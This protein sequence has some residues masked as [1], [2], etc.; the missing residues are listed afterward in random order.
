MRRFGV[1]K[2]GPSL[3]L[4]ERRRRELI[5]RIERERAALRVKS[6][7]GRKQDGLCRVGAVREVKRQEQKV[8]V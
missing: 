4:R 6:A 8:K 2:S 1:A 5:R 7:A 3:W